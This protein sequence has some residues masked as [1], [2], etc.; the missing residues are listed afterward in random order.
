MAA[1]GC[2][3]YGVNLSGVQLHSLRALSARTGVAYGRV[4]HADMRHLPFRGRSFD[5]VMSIEALYHVPEPESVLV[6]VERVLVLGGRWGLDDWFLTSATREATAGRLRHN[7]STP[8]RGFHVF[9]DMVRVT[10]RAGLV[11]EEIVDHTVRAGQFFTEERF[12]A[13]FDRQIAPL[14]VRVFPLLYHYDGYRPQHAYQAVS[15]LRADI[16]LMGR[17]TALVRPSTGRSWR[18]SRL[19][20]SRRSWPGNDPDHRSAL[21]AAPDSTR[22]ADTTASSPG[23]VGCPHTPGARRPVIQAPRSAAGRSA[24]RTAHAGR[25]R[26]RGGTP[27]AGAYHRD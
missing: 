11:V 20:S 8:S 25:R 16:L 5:A 4:V 12:G 26:P 27:A 15:Q 14:L 21:R 6:E 3:M 23:S 22:T 9:D 17:S 18:A 1:T 19:G 10:I 7:W 2:E 13:I 24:S